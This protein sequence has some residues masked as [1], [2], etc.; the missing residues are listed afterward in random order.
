LGA[1]LF[2]DATPASGKSL[3]RH[4]S[5]QYQHWRAGDDKGPSACKAETQ[6]ARGFSDHGRILLISEAD[7]AVNDW[8]SFYSRMAA[9]RASQ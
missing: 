4:P 3:R 2:A 5:P 6:N 7:Q 1:Q 9:R 8:K